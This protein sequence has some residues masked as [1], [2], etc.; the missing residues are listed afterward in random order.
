MT[1]SS[2]HND[3]TLLE[4]KFEKFFML[5]FPKVKHF[6]WRLLKSE[7]DAE[8]I[9]QE[10]FLK[11]WSRPELW[12]DE[13]DAANLGSYL[14]TMTKNRVIDLTRMRVHESDITEEELFAGLEPLTTDTDSPLEDIYLKEVQLILKLSLER[15]PPQRRRVFE[16]SR[17]E[18]LSN[19][20]IAERLSLSVR[21]VEHHLYLALQEL[22]KK[23]IFAVLLLFI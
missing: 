21:T 14:F 22:K 16:M 20:E 8:D 10:V 5:H 3:M 23:L 4:R 7:V 13:S 12:Y 19:L 2:L 15:M 6:A 11:L 9:A 17:Q 18:G 1:G